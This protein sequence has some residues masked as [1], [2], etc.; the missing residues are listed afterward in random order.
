MSLGYATLVLIVY[1]LAVMRLVRLVNGD[2][3][4][5]RLRLIPARR[6]KTAHDIAAEAE[7]LGQVERARV[8]REVMGRWNK[9]L[10]FIECPWCVGMWAAFATAW[11]P[12][13]FHDNV[14]ARYVA[15]ALATSHLIG[16]CARFADTEEIEI[17]D[18]DD[19]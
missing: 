8:Y 9:V 2:A 3:I 12:L 13:F 19:Q 11:V 18:V 6:A 14:V 7:Q 4:L 5:D 1:V 10:Y 16:V 17:E 15:I